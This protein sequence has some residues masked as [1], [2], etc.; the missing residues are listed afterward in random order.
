[1]EQEGAGAAEEVQGV[2][3][4]EVAEGVTEVA[5]EGVVVEV[6]SGVVEAE[7]SGVVA[8]GVAVVD[9]KCTDLTERIVDLLA[10]LRRINASHSVNSCQPTLALKHGLNN[11]IS[12]DLLKLQLLNMV[13]PVCCGFLL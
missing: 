5:S 7:V 2:A 1:M 10:N 11:S 4:G 6:A 12:S 9:S 13:M 8:A 3:L